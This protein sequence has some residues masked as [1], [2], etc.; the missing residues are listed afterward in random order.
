VKRP[1]LACT[2]ILA[3]SLAPTAAFSKPDE[4]Q[5]AADEGGDAASDQPAEQQPATSPPREDPYT[6]G[7]YYGEL[8]PPPKSAFDKDYPVCTKEIQDGCL[9]PNQLKRKRQAEQRDEQGGEG[10]AS[11]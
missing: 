4:P 11:E 3:L 2:A 5:D 7:S 6:T 1:I 8:T 10:E 9:N